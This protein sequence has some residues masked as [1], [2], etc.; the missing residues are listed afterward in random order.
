VRDTGIGIAPEAQARL[1]KAFSQ[2]DGSTSRRFGGTGLGLAISKQL[3]E[4]MGGRVQIE[5]EA[6]RGS[7]FSFTAR[8]L[9]AARTHVAKASNAANPGAAALAPG[10]SRGRVLLVEDNGVNQ[11]LAKAMLHHLGFEVDTAADG[12][13]GVTAESAHDY[14]A[15]LMDCQMP[16]MDGFQATA[17]IRLREAGA[18]ASA[19]APRR[20]PILALTANAMQGDRERCI[21]GGMD[22]YLA[23]PF[24]KDQLAAMLERW[25]GPGSKST[26]MPGDASPAAAR[27]PVHA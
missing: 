27:N 5:S 3:V 18:G 1:F 10:L 14:D 9:Q 8:L 12:R 25:I 11:E 13:A 21:T 22:D 15:V 23:K 26:A 7:T 17:A 20:V 24:T 16:E 2:A 6:G 19:F 4:L